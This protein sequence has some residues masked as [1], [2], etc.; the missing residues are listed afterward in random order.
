MDHIAFN[1]TDVSG[2]RCKKPVSA[3][4]AKPYTHGDTHQVREIKLAVTRTTVM[5]ILPM[6]ASPVTIKRKQGHIQN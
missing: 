5:R 6:M 4:A 3:V 2:N 1:S